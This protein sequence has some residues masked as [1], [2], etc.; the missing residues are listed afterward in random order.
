MSAFRANGIKIAADSLVGEKQYWK[1]DYPYYQKFLSHQTYT[2][3]DLTPSNQIFQK[4]SNFENIILFNYQGQIYTK[5]TKKMLILKFR[6]TDPSF[7]ETKHWQFGNLALL[8]IWG[9]WKCFQS[10]SRPKNTYRQIFRSFQ[11]SVQVILLFLEKNSMAVISVSAFLS[12]RF[13]EN[14]SVPTD[15]KIL[16]YGLSHSAHN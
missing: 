5:I 7:C 12:P 13:T 2:R 4:R 6:P 10:I 15:F 11:L 1:Q 8:L 3:I 14:L 9:R 16:R